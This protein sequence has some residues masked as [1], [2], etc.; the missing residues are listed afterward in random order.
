M[1]VSVLTVEPALR[2]DVKIAIDRQAREQ[3]AGVNAG[4]R[5]PIGGYRCGAAEAN[6]ADCAEIEKRRIHAG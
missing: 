3:I 1:E 4:A 2:N 5:E 6:G